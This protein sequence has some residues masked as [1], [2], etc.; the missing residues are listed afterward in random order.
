MP[1]ISSCANFG[2]LKSLEHN[3]DSQLM[4]YTKETNLFNMSTHD[5]RRRLFAVYS[6]LHKVNAYI[7][8]NI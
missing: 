2:T 5:Y 8:F 4:K 6:Y 3:I 7:L 1:I